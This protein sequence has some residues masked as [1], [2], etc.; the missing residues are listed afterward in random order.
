M[1][2]A[3]E[4]LRNRD[5]GNLSEG[6]TLIENVYMALLHR[7]IKPTERDYIKRGIKTPEE[8]KIFERFITFIDPCL[9]YTSPSPR[10]S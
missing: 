7:G 2:Q 4:W 9:L 3:R 5:S 10:D 8:K 1:D 6:N